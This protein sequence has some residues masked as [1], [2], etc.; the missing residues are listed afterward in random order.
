MISRELV[1]KAFSDAQAQHEQFAVDPAAFAAHVERCGV[2]ETGLAQHAA[3]VYLACACAAANP[4]AIAVLERR[5]MARIP[6]FLHQYDPRPEFADEVLQQ[7]RCKLLLGEPPR[8]SQYSATG[9]L[10]AWIRMAAIRLALDAI[11]GRKPEQKAGDELADIMDGAV[12]PELDA[13]RSRFQPLFQ[14]ALR[15][16]IAAIPSDDRMILWLYFGKDLSI[17]EISGMVG[18]H[19]AT[20][21]RRISRTGDKLLQD[22]RREL[23]DT[24][25][26]A[27]SEFDSMCRMVGYDLVITMRAL[28]D[29]GDA[30]A[31]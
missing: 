16:A 1:E 29:S 14:E 20:V 10:G 23:V 25:G 4:A 13:M 21:A 7:V 8:I 26:V 28:R 31:T 15:K 3:D 6:S 5:E 24:Q 19:R 12:S 30:P 22:V 9:P 11:R 18:V 27:P 17:D 2:S